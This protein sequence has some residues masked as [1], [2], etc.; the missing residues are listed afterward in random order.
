MKVRTEELVSTRGQ[1]NHWPCKLATLMT[2]MK[3][4]RRRRRAGL[5]SLYWQSSSDMLLFREL[6]RSLQH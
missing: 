4:E 2:I 1:P 3:V 5:V 6:K